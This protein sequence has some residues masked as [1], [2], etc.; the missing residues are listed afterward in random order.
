MTIL[1][2]F[3]YYF[4]TIPLPLPPS[5]FDNL[6]KMISQ[7][8]W[9]NRRA[10][11]RLKLLYLP[12]ERGG[13]QIPEL[14]ICNYLYSADLHKLKKQ[15]KNPFLKNTIVVWH[16]A[17]KRGRNYKKSQFTPLWNNDQFIPGRNDGGFKLWKNKGI[18]AIKDLYING[19][20]LTFNDLSEKYQ[21]PTKHF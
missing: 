19:K 12:N 15:T 7:F 16:T 1:P 2:K 8:I 10:R 11:L 18:Q 5:F 4:Q 3:L 14:P 6:N 9:N 20:L 17:H 13:M 21:L